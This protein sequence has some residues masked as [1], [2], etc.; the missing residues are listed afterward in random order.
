MTQ[1]KTFKIKHKIDYSNE[2]AKAR[3]I[4][5]WAIQNKRKTS[6]KEV[7]HFGLKSTIANQILKKYGLNQKVKAITSV[8]LTIPSNNQKDIQI[9]NNKIYIPCLN[10][11][12]ITPWFD[13]SQIEKINQVEVDNEYYYISCSIKTEIPYKSNE[14]L[15]I[16][17]NTAEHAI[18]VANGVK[19]LKRGKNIPHIKNK[20]SHKR[21]KLQK[22]KKF[23]ELKKIKNKEQRV[24]KD[25]LHKITREIVDL[26][27]KELKGIRLEDLSFIRNQRTYKGKKFNRSTNNW[28]FAQFRQMIEYKSKICGVPVEIINPAYTSQT[29]SKC[30]SIGK[31]TGKKFK[32]PSCGHADHADANASFNIALA[33]SGIAITGKVPSNK[34]NG[35]RNKSSELASSALCMK[36]TYQEAVCSLEQQ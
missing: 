28:N 4:A 35:F 15:G 1:I 27:K 6:S 5:E 12:Y 24:I 23:N 26:A 34:A 18:V 7:K 14:Y 11:L 17:L 29:C 25:Q 13:L 8:K 32:C 33:I 31:R 3:L 22:Q 19:I 36:D 20:Y 30:G 21:R 16:D 9:K 2:L 10:K